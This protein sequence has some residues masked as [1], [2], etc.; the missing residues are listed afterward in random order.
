M[1]TIVVAVFPPPFTYEAIMDHLRDV[2]TEELTRSCRFCVNL[3]ITAARQG[4]PLHAKYPDRFPR[5]PEHKCA[6]DC[7]T[8]V[9]ESIPSRL[10]RAVDRYLTRELNPYVRELPVENQGS[11]M[12]QGTNA[13]ERAANDFGRDHPDV[14]CQHSDGGM[15]PLNPNSPENSAAL[16][17]GSTHDQN[18]IVPFERR[19]RGNP[20][21]GFSSSRHQTGPPSARDNWAAEEPYH[22]PLKIDWICVLSQRAQGFT[23][24]AAEARCRYK[25]FH[26]Q[27]QQQ[28]QQLAR[29][30]QPLAI[31]AIPG[32]A[33]ILEPAPAFV[34]PGSA[35][36]LKGGV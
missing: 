17:K 32:T 31:P 10:Q 13:L 28:Q 25:P 27:Q 30:G 20:P 3:C 11:A 2:I 9:Q 19:S 21:S 24:A 14:K 18:H 12:D 6:D 4:S 5:T 7:S 16:K 34:A 8:K 29:P 1:P 15:P 23:P 33:P 26:K 36:L 35:L 22:T